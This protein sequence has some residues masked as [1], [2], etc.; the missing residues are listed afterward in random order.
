[1]ALWGSVL[2]LAGALDAMGPHTAVRLAE[3]LTPEECS[4]FQSLLKAP[5]PDVEEELARLSED[6]SV[7]PG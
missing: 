3:L 6:R 5:D 7:G 1:M 2:V 4:H